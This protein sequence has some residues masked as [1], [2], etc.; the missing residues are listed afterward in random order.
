VIF[1]RVVEVLLL[2][3]I[4]VQTVLALP[5]LV[6]IPAVSKYRAELIAVGVG[7]EEIVEV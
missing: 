6:Q 2:A 4:V 3:I 1:R 5:K 7:V